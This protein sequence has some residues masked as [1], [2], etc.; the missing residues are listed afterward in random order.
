MII[1]SFVFC[2]ILASVVWLAYWSKSRAGIRWSFS[3]SA[4]FL[5]FTFG[6][7]FL[8]GALAVYLLL[9]AGTIMASRWQLRPRWF[10]AWCG[11]AVLA[12]FGFMVI[13]YI[14]IYQEH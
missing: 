6:F 1:V 3:L 7:Y 12:T 14:P 13:R 8:N 9:L 10:A 2:V 11:G 5:L 4:A